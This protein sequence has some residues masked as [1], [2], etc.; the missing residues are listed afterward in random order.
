[1]NFI[2]KIREDKKTFNEDIFQRGDFETSISP[3][4]QFRL[5]ATNFWVATM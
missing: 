3:S 1:M 4:K 5:D 2:D